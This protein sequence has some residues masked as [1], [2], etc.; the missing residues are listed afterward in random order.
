[1]H[2]RKTVRVEDNVL[3]SLHKKGIPHLSPALTQLKES[4][5]R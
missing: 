5:K 4:D 3:I 2:S 1:M